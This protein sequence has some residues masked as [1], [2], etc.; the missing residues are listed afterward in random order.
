M[1]EILVRPVPDEYQT[2][3]IEAHKERASTGVS[4]SWFANGGIGTDA[5]GLY[6]TDADGTR[7][8]LPCPPNGE[9]VRMH[10]YGYSQGSRS[11]MYELFVADEQ[12]H[13]V[14]ELPIAG[15]QHVDGLG[16]L[17][18]A[19]GLRFAEPRVDT[20]FNDTGP[21]YG[22]EHT[23]DTVDLEKARLASSDRHTIGRLFHR[24]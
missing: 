3:R 8:T 11:D 18:V 17:A 5:G 24:H 7:H 15:F 13:R 9:L 4:A 21:H 2:S 22:Y 6:L 16:A 12:H 10:L 14:A 23:D 20:T 1:A 19:V